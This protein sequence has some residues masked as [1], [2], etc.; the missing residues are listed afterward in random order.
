MYEKQ[1]QAVDECLCR[2]AMAD[3]TDPLLALDAHPEAKRIRSR[4]LS[5]GVATLIVDA[6]GLRDAERRIPRL[7]SR[8][9]FP[10][11]PGV[12]QVRIAL[13]ASQPHRTL[14][15]IGS[16]KGGVGK[17]TSPQISRSPWLGRNKKVGMVDADIYGPSQPTL[18]GSA[19]K[20][21]RK[22][23]LIPVEAQG[24]RFLSIGQ[25]VSPG[26]RWRG[27]GR[28]RQAHLPS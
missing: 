16:G 18:L 15:A 12:D 8:R 3:Q 19:A 1:W 17:S 22:N 2:P 10:P 27:A 21:R 11:I 25:L 5:G 13:T 6:T 28:W 24:V 14:I 20:P 26:R 23:Q 9:K 7:L 4:R